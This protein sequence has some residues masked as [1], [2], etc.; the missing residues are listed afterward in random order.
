M[1]EGLA[2]LRSLLPTATNRDGV[3][4]FYNVVQICIIAYWNSRSAVIDLEGY[5]E[6]DV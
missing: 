2:T 1:A 4:H 3:G 5:V 6:K